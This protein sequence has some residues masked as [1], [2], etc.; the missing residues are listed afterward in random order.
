MTSDNENR[1]KLFYMFLDNK[2]VLKPIL[3][4]IT[5]MVATFLNCLWNVSALVYLV[6]LIYCL[7][8]SNR[9]PN[10]SEHLFS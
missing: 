9:F 8:L 1:Q 10:Y 5:V 7:L 3:N 4:S 2:S 6:Y